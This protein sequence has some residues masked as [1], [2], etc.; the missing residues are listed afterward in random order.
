[1][2]DGETQGLYVV[3]GVVLVRERLVLRAEAQV[4]EPADL[5]VEHSVEGISS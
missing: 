4:H 5:V 3:H 2:Q 1:M